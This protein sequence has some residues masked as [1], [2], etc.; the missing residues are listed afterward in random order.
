MSEPIKI[1]VTAETADAAAKLQAFM[2]SSTGGFKMAE[3]AAHGA[4]SAFGQNRAAIMELEHSAR[5]M[6]DGLAAGMSPL[7]LLMME[8]PRLGQSMTEMS[9]DMRAKLLSFLPVLGGIGVALGIGAVA[10]HVYGDAITD[11]TKRARE[12]ADALDKIP[13]LLQKIQIAQR[14]GDISGGMAQTFQDML[15]GATKL[16]NVTTLFDAYGGHAKTF[17]PSG[18]M[19]G[20]SVPD[21]STDPYTRNRSGQITGQ[22][23]E[24][25]EADVT[26]YV[27]YQMKHA[28]ATDANE[29]TKMASQASVEL[30][31]KELQLQRDS[32]VG[33]QRMIDR[34]RDRNALEL[35]HLEILKEEMQAGGKW[36]PDQEAKYQAA[37]KNSQASLQQSIAEEQARA[38]K[39]AAEEQTQRVQ[40]QADSERTIKEDAAKQAKDDL[41]AVEDQIT[42]AQDKAGNQRGALIQQEYQLRMDA[43]QRAFFSGEIG[44]DEYTH[45]LQEAAHKRTEAEKEYNQQLERSAA[46]KKQIAQMDAEAR[47][48]QIDQDPFLTKNEKQ[49]ASVAPLTQQLAAN[50]ND[51]ADQQSII[52]SNPADSDKALEAQAKL[53][54]LLSQQAEIRGKITAADNADNFGYQILQEITNLQSLGTVAQQ[55]AAAFGSAWTTATN[56]ISDNISKVIQG[57]ETWR[58]A[59]VRIYNTVLNDVVTSFTKMA[60]EWVLQHSIMLAAEYAFYE[61]CSVLGWTN[62]ANVTAAKLAEVGIH[63]A[64]ETTKTATSVA[65]ATTQISANAMVAGSGAAAS[66][67]SIPYVGPILAIAAMA[68]IIA[69]VIGLAGGFADGG[70]VQGPGTGTSDSIMARLSHGE[71][72]MPA[73]AVSRIGLNNLEAMRT[74]AYGGSSM[75][76]AGRSSGARVPEHRTDSFVY[77]DSNKMM[78]HLQ[79]SDAH[80]KIVVDIMSRN[81]H[82]FR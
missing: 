71:F 27:Q 31:E 57:T 25:N 69:A 1:V 20:Q 64:A 42:A 53:N 59:T 15:T 63:V 35:R 82:R 44:E 38:D 17:Q 2:A 40:K 33:A 30:Q 76:D 74:G 56:S 68:A 51:V 22:R 21:L 14:A 13:D 78:D 54:D 32:E 46:L 52:N 39:Q 48:K 3:D 66:M 49:Q 16:Y 7:R 5:A 6:A 67:A 62:L 65:S 23:Q 75:P 43:A 79:K 28:G 72:V 45:L 10:W 12:L 70:L 60:V 34:L 55:T 29:K 18:T 26:S 41:Q 61:I 9:A 81:I 4:T 11:P 77:F 8:G 80:E 73:S 50:I 19:F 47:L 37:L 36:S 58:Q 24:A